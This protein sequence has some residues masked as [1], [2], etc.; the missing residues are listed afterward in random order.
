MVGV[1]GLTVASTGASEKG[2]R[3]A[4]VTDFQKVYLHPGHHAG[5][6]PGAEPIHLKLLFSSRD[7]GI[8]GAQAVGIEG[9][10]KRIDVIAT[11]IQMGATVRDLAEAELCYA[12]QFGAAKDPVNLAGMIA[13]NYLDGDMP[14]ADW[15]LSAA[16]T[17]CWSTCASRASS[18]PDTSRAPS[19]YR[20]RRCAGVTRELP[21]NRSLSLCC[22]VGQRAYYATRFLAQHGYR[23]ANLSGGYTTYLAMRGAGG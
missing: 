23:A 20:C 7:G 11:A 12:P 8:L 6:Y 1:F 3:R 2:L 19:T 18:Q 15:P 22:S 13:T 17:R 16:A 9:V 14:L 10:E 4:G 21:A 5:Y